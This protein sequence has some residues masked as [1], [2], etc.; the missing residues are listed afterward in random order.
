MDVFI[1]R[2]RKE[3]RGRELFD[4]KNI[5]FKSGNINV[6]MGRNG[7]GK[8]TLLNIVAG[9]DTDY[10]GKILYD[11]SAIDE[12]KSKDITLVSQKPYILKRSVYENLAY[13]LRLRGWKKSD[14]E[15]SVESYIVKM[16]LENL[17]GQSGNSLSGGEMQ[18]VSLAR[19]LI[20]SPR[21]LLLDEYTASIDEKSMDLME[22][23]VIDYKNSTG[24]N[25][26]LITHSKD[27]ADRVGD[28]LIEMK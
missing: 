22:S 2:V 13:P 19:A 28:S 10:D 18:R 9:L 25:V 5:E 8:T 20:F 14:I 6:L 24:A 21:L 17:R 26:I 4:L 11:G 23:V 7:I 27:Q 16:K 15:E 1:E 12:E 3:F